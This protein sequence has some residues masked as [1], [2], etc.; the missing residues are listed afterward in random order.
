MYIFQKDHIIIIVGKDFNNFKLDFRKLKEQL[1]VY[2][3][4]ELH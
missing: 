3:H 2:D 4:K 1:K